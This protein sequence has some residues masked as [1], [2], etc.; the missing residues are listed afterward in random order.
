MSSPEEI[1]RSVTGCDTDCRACIKNDD[2]CESLKAARL[3]WQAGRKEAFWEARDAWHASFDK[4]GNYQRW[5]EQKAG[6]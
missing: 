6:A 1:A 2:I 5:I 4:V 3:A